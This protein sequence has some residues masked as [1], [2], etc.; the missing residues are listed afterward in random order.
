MQ[1]QPEALPG[2]WKKCGSYLNSLCNWEILPKEFGASPG[3]YKRIVTNRTRNLS[4]RVE[5]KHPYF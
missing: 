2:D 1:N 5:G 4:R 3:K